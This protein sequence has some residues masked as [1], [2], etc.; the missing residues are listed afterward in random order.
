L[1]FINALR[2]AKKFDLIYGNEL[3][4]VVIRGK[5]ELNIIYTSVDRNYGV[6]TECSF[7]KTKVNSA[8]NYCYFVS[9]MQV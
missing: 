5:L 1:Y 3:K 9:G 8:T 2:K 7:D 4:S 6:I